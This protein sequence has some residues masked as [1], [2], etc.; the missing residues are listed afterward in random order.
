MNQI[1]EDIDLIDLFLIIWNGKKTLIIFIFISILIGFA[2][3]IL[4]DDSLKKP[5]YQ[6]NLEYSVIPIPEF[7]NTNT[8]SVLEDFEK[9]FYL[10]NIFDEWKNQNSQSPINFTDITNT[11]LID[12][13]IYRKNENE[14]LVS[15]NK[16]GHF[17]EIILKTDQI[18]FLDEINKYIDHVNFKIT[19]DYYLKFE[20]LLKI[21]KKKNTEFHEDF[22]FAEANQIFY[23]I[24]EIELLLSILGDGQKIIDLLPPTTPLD[25]S[26]KG[27]SKSFVITALGIFGFLTGSIFL[28]VRHAVIRRKMKK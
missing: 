10:K 9:N 26:D 12:D 8:S 14:L 5:V 6:T 13:I 11:K 25:I 15:F 18:I 2:F 19:N 23:R 1:S 28:F 4:R 21:I 17:N 3:L 22:P 20:E 16:Q 24:I 27:P 7:Y